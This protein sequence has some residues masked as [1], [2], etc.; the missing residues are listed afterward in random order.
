[1]T[2]WVKAYIGLGSNL[3]DPESQLRQGFAALAGLTD[4]RNLLASDLY[5]SLPFGDV[6]QPNFVNAVAAMETRCSPQALLT[7]LQGIEH[8][9]GRTRELRWG[10]RT[11]DLDILLYGG[12]IVDQPD[13]IIPHPG[14]LQRDF[15]LYPLFEIASEIVIPGH[16]RIRGCLA[17]CPNRGLQRLHRSPLSGSLDEEGTIIG[18]T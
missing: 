8:S 5:L 6:D 18:A 4:C 9:Q 12:E 14:L 16:G 15:V 2:H 3:N 17:A 10:P 13:L 1:M 7:A 11:L